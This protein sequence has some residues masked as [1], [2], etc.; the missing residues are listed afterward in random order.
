ME[1][2]MLCHIFPQWEDD[3]RAENTQIIHYLHILLASVPGTSSSLSLIPLHQVFACKTH[4]ISP[5][6]SGDALQKKTS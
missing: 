1:L 5:L 2:L 6:N 3:F 4:V